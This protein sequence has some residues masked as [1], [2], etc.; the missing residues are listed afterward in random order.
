VRRA[1]VPAPDTFEASTESFEESSY[2]GF[3]RLDVR[4]IGEPTVDLVIAPGLSLSS[5]AI[6]RWA[7]TELDGVT[8]YIGRPPSDSLSVFVLPGSSE[9]M[10]GKTLGGGGASVFMRVGTAA[11]EAALLDDWVL[12][13]ELIHVGFPSTERTATWF[14]E[15]L[16]SYVEPVIRARAG[17]LSKEKFW[18]D[19]V[20]GLP[21]GL[22]GAADK[23]LDYDDSWG[24]V[25]WG[26]SLYFLLADLAIRERTAGARS[27]EDSVRAVATDS[28][29]VE[30]FEPLKRVLEIGDRATGTRVLTELY[31][32]MAKA[33]G[34]EDLE[35]LWSRLGV[36]RDGAE[37]RFDDRAPAAALRDAIPAPRSSHL[38]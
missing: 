31:E 10:R 18:K 19:L 38:R 34:A 5:E 28:G 25:Y 15:G 29:N 3:G 32:R 12:C 20:D 7:K 30:V 24:R 33:P 4:R 2:A 27:L 35:A 9:V 1:K 37:I 22:P 11:T 23:G 21:Q 17:L 6:V 14:S 8:R 26:G 16:A 36:V 13:H